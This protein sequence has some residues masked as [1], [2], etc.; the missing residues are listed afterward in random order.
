MYFQVVLDSPT[1]GVMRFKDTHGN[2]YNVNRQMYPFLRLHDI[3]EGSVTDKIIVDEL[4]TDDDDVVNFNALEHF[5]QQQEDEQRKKIEAQAAA[6]VV[7]AKEQ[8]DA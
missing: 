1:R 3:F 4:L 8:E 2:F 6:E 7:K 5:R